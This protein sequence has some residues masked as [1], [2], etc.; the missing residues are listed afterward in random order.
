MGTDAKE[1]IR[2]GMPCQEGAATNIQAT[3]RSLHP[4]GV[5]VAFAD[6]GARFIPNSIGL[7]TVSNITDANA[8]DNFSELGVWDKLVL[9]SDGQSIDAESIQ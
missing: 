1:R 2:I 7:G 8:L 5:N 4:G 6:G 3:N 9:S